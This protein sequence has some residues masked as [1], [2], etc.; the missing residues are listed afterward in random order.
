MILS[1]LIPIY[2]QFHLEIFSSFFPKIN[3]SEEVVLLFLL[4]V[5]RHLPND[6]DDQEWGGDT[7]RFLSRDQIYKK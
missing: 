6:E 1:T 3:F 7:I 2:S 5:N 4:N